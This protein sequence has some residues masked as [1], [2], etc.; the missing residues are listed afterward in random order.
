MMTRRYNSG[1]FIGGGIL[2]GLGLLFLLAQ[3]FNFSAWG[4]LWP[5]FVI[6]IGGLFFIGMLSGGK[7]AAPLAIPGSIIGVKQ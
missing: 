1:G 3:L 7:A 6:G 2:V 4:L 5:L